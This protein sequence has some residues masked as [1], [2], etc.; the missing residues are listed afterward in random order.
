[1]SDIHAG[2]DGEGSENSLQQ[3]QVA[4]F[5]RLQRYTITE[6]FGAY[7]HSIILDSRE[8]TILTGSNGTGKSTILRT[9]NMIS[10]GNWSALSKIRFDQIRLDF[11]LARLVVGHRKNGSISLRLDHLP[12][13]VKTW[14]Y[15]PK[16]DG[17]LGERE[18]II[19]RWLGEEVPI[20][21]MLL[22]EYSS[23]D[24][25]EYRRI[26]NLL[27]HRQSEKPR[28]V[29]KIHQSFPALLVSDQRLTPE[30]RM[31]PKKRG[32]GEAIQVVAAIETAVEHINA[33][34]R[35]YQLLYGTE[36]QNLD[37]DFPRRVFTAISSPIGYSSRESVMREFQEVQAL[38]VSLAAAGL[39]DSS[40]A[41]ESIS[42]LPLESADS[43]A[44]ISTYISDTKKKLTTFEPLRRRL[45]PFM[46]FLRRH[47]KDKRVGIDTERGFRIF[48]ER[49]GEEINPVQL[50][51]GEQQMFV[52]S[53]KL[54][55]ESRPG[56]LVMI[57]EPELS[58]HVLWQATFVDDLTE[59]SAVSGTYFMLATH[60]PTLI[61]GRSDLRRSLDA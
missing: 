46:D 8:P 1:M 21:P 48:S 3:E 22:A 25:E 38:R 15:A 61:A 16:S 60:S 44:L 28:W 30:R 7:S 24:V 51:S 59:I 19:A 35:R 29:E 52:L 42:D 56:T 39:I 43:L 9:I 27:A 55:F 4:A 23:S 2:M 34:V 47:Y 32:S 40:E 45:E 26:H 10:G 17:I 5:G 37:R 12:H 54:L 6:L 49:T 20:D 58:L 50:S 36:S 13:K 11:E 14:E 41:G 33:E 18:E 57:D 31:R 53:H